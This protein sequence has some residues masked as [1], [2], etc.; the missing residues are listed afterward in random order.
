MSF[1]AQCLSALDTFLTPPDGAVAGV[2]PEVMPFVLPSA[3][4]V[5]IDIPVCWRWSELRHCFQLVGSWPLL[6]CSVVLTLLL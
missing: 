6:S 4:E 3:I 2:P 1:G 5:K